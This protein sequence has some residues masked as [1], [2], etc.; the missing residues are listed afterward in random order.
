M[1]RERVKKIK[2]AVSK[3]KSNA[4]GGID[5]P[6][7]ILVLCLLAFGLV[8]VC[9]A[10][11]V[12][13]YYNYGDSFYFF[14]RQFIFAILG[15]IAM[16]FFAFADYRKFKKY[17]LPIIII[18]FIMAVLVLVPGIG[19]KVNG[20]RRWL[21]IGSFR[22]Q[23]SEVVKF[24]MIVYLSAY[25]SANYERMKTFRGLLPAAL[26]LVLFTGVVAVE[27]HISGA[28][29]IFCVGVILMLVGGMNIR[30]FMTF[31]GVG[32]GAIAF[33]VLFTDYAKERLSSW[34]DP[35][36][37]PLG[38]GFQTIQSLY[39][40]GSG[41]LGGLGLGQSVQKHLYL[42]EPHN[43]YIFSII[44]EELGFV[45]AAAVILLFVLLIWRGFTI[46]FRQ[47]D[48]F[49]AMMVIGIVSGVAIQAIFNMM[50]VTNLFPSTGIS[51]PFFSYGGTALIIL[52]SEMGIVLSISRN[53]TTEEVQV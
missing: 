52:L 32:V 51:L 11:Y 34:L 9:S 19:I 21:G 15:C 17:V 27:T 46:A 29:L 24:A 20:A 44:C 16:M 5:L 1:A 22:I 39:A 23:P 48:K 18:A 8:M 42:P 2:S 4:R 14:K 50:V 53:N 25:V 41:G 12:S 36:G 13:A 33:I 47:K 26:V 30:T 7:L 10:S 49:S 43:D 45:G 3:R 6:F 28:I 40:I 38:S 31:G 35:F 37:D